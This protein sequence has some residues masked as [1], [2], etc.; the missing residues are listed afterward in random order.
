MPGSVT[1]IN[2]YPSRR[3]A[4]ML[5]VAAVL[6]PNSTGVAAEQ[7]PI[8]VHN[9][10]NCG[11]CAGWVRHLQKNGFATNVVET[12]QID[13]VKKRL[14]VPD[15]IA[16]C[17]TGEI[18]GYVIEGH[19]PAQ[20]VRRLLT[21]KPTAT[22]LAVPGMPMSSPG[23]EGGTLETYEVVLFGPAGCRP[24]MRFIGERPA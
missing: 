17:H 11:C 8:T 3:S 1:L 16:S 5:E 12:P 18:A 15:D 21:E 23:M 7:A 14:G 22:G 13:A 9:D 20:A 19:I 2:D 6:S 4:L 24:Y 10:P